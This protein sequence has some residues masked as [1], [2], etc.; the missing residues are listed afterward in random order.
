[1]QPDFDTSLE[2]PQGIVMPI[3]R[4]A[5]VAAGA[6]LVTKGYLTAEQL[7]AVVGGLMAL[8]TTGWL[9]FNKKVK[10]V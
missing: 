2:S 8:A 5:L 3:I 10:G 7:Q 4:Y 9:V 6:S 1:M